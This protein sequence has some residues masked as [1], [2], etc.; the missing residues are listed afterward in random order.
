MMKHY[1]AILPLLDKCKTM[2]ELRQLH[3]LMITTSVIKYVIPL[4][5]LIDF[6][7]NPK[8][9]DLDYAESVFSQI[10][11]PSAYIWN[12]MIKTYSNSNN[13]DEAVHMYREM[14]RRGYSPDHFTFPFVLKACSVVTN[15]HHGKCIHCRILKTGFELDMY[16]SCGLLNMYVSCA[17]MVAGLKVFDAIPKWNVV[18]WTSLISGYVNNG[19]P[20]KAI[21]LYKDMEFWGVEPNEITLVNV[22]VACSH[23]RDIDSGKWV[24]SRVCQLGYDPFESDSNFNVILATAII[25]MYAKC[26]SF[27]YARKLF[28]KMPKKSL[29]V[30]NSMVGA[31]NQYGRVEEALG[32]FRDMMI[33]GF[34][35]D[36]ATFLSGIGVCAHLGA[37]ALGQNIHSF[38]LKTN[39]VKDIAVGTALL[40]MYAKVGDARSSHKIFCELQKKDAIAWTSMIIGLAMHGH[41]EEALATFKRMQED[42]NVIPDKITYIGVLS[43]CGHL[44]L[45]EEGQ[46]HFTSMADDYSIEP[47]V[48]HYGCMVDLLSRAGHFEKAERLVEKM[49]TQPNIAIWGALLNGCEIHGNVNLADQ[50]R[51]RITELEPQGSGVYVLLSNI[52]ARVGK[53]QEAKLARELMA[54]RRIAKTRGHSAIELKLLYS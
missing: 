16:A 10:E 38:V 2:T 24:H 17:D 44:G 23:S 27:G 33:G 29:V 41:A 46:R 40:D 18:A 5:R 19:W 8:A 32:L 1:N 22:L 11:V 51:S 36:T 7:A 13:P 54:H 4:S 30:W 26:G 20:R 39:I 35:P 31:Y 25:D 14:Q 43:A 49:P 47:T 48:E 15:P 12:S 6:C 53:W 9:G 37:L 52:Y 50:L 28:N 42:P 45:V 21:E 34:Q 3:G